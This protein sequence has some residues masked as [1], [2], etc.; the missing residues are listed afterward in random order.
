[1]GEFYYVS[2]THSSEYSIYLQVCVCVRARARLNMN[3][4][5]ISLHNLIKLYNI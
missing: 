5:I 1:M 3:K 4:S 2:Y